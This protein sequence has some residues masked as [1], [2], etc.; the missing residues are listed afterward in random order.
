GLSGSS[1][2]SGLSGQFRSFG[3]FRSTKTPDK[4]NKPDKPN[5]G[6]LAS[7][8]RQ[9]FLQR[10]DDMP[11]RHPNAPCSIQQHAGLASLR[12]TLHIVADTVTHMHRF[13]R[14][15]RM[16]LKGNLENL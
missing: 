2:L 3:F 10:P 4:L 12:R 6:L 16:F 9:Q 7:Y 13:A 5:N 8:E 11:A 1:G 15:H 14:I